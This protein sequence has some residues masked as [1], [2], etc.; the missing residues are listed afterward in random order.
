M[1]YHSAPYGQATTS[2]SAITLVT[3]NR[4]SYLEMLFSNGW[5]A[6]S[7][8]HSDALVNIP[9]AQ[10]PLVTVDRLKAA[11]ASYRS[12]N[13]GGARAPPRNFLIATGARILCT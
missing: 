2:F 3:P 13:Y 10:A 12:D 1:V 9:H 5:T 11:F 7:A 8:A 4:K 6:L